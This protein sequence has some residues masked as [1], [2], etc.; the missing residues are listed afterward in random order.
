MRTLCLLLLVALLP[1]VSALAQESGRIDT[2]DSL[3]QRIQELEQ[4]VGGDIAA[5]RQSVSLRWLA[6]LYVQAGRLNDAEAAYQR[7][8]VFFPGDV[9]TSNDYARFLLEHRDDPVTAEKALHDAIQ[10]AESAPTPPPYLG[11]TF[12]LRARAL[13]ELAR[14]DESLRQSERAL[15][16]LDD[17]AAEEA[18][19][20]KATCL[21]EMDRADDAA[22][23]WR[24]L[25]GISHASNPDDKAA[26]LALTAR[27]GVS[28][29]RFQKEIAK[30]IADARKEREKV[31]K[32]EGARIIDITAP[33]GVLLEATLR[34]GKEKAAVLFVPE[35]GSRR[36]AF[37]PYAQLM[38]LDGVTTL[39][40]DTRGQGDSRSDTI[41]S[42][43]AMSTYNAG[44]LPA[45]V[46][47]AVHWLESKGGVP[48]DRIAVVAEGGAAVW[49]ERALREQNI[50]PI[51]VYLSPTFDETDLDLMSALAFRA[52]RPLLVLASD[53]DV[54]AMRSLGFFTD[55]VPTDGSASTT[56]TQVRVFS[57][58][59][60]GVSLMRDP[61]HFADIHAWLRRQLGFQG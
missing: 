61:G 53:E 8:L 29:E 24:H 30:A 21:Q 34:P 50:S 27:K 17:K 41:P 32:G 22:K 20:V 13:L 33:D 10:W 45:D 25:I 42:P 19:R 28:A 2:R 23:A 5:E 26:L 60:H 9:A 16:L 58:A 59:G 36:S 31:A 38:T 35:G 3:E 47:A 7:I 56:T 14:Y 54:Y 11:T 57:F 18:L 39:T 15:E 46:A 48:R 44:Q 37:T 55:N 1:A 4:L 12:A 52:P 43:E 40:L 51:A 49:V 6:D